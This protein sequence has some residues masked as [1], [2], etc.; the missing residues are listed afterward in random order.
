MASSQLAMTSS[1]ASA[2]LH[3]EDEDESPRGITVRKSPHSRAAPM[4]RPNTE[5]E[6]QAERIASMAHNSGRSNHAR[7]SSR[8]G[9]DGA[10]RGT[11]SRSRS[12]YTDA[13]E[14]VDSEEGEIASEEQARFVL[15]WHAMARKREAEPVTQRW[16]PSGH[17]TANAKGNIGVS[18][19]NLSDVIES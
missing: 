19:C 2:F 13:T 10:R 9:R 3:T 8:R 15:E 16:Q 17:P 4:C 5:M 6:V 1:L 18:Y 12:V 11:R 14:L 7:S